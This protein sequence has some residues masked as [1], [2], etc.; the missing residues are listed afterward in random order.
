M[1]SMSRLSA[2]T[3]LVFA[4]LLNC[5][6]APAPSSGG[7][8]SLCSTIPAPTA[9][10]ASYFEFQVEVPATV[11]GG[12]PRYQRGTVAGEILMQFVVS[13]LGVPDMTTFKVLKTSDANLEPHARTI[14]ASLRFHPAELVRGCPVRQLAQEVFEFR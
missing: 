2:A 14:V 11:P 3:A 1:H 10:A 12:F 13:T 5:Q 8:P 7:N 4:P 6:P 9:D